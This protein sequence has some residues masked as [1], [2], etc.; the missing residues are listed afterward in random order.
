MEKATIAAAYLKSAA[1]V[2]YVFGYEESGTVYA[3]TLQGLT[4]ETLTAL[5]DGSTNSSTAADALKYKATKAR[6]ALLGSIGTVRSVC[7]AE[8]FTALLDEMNAG[9]KRYNR[10]D[11]FEAALCR[12]CGGV[13]YGKQN[14]AYTEHGD[15]I[16]DG[17]DCQAKY[18]GA[19]FSVKGAK[20]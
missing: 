15:L 20:G 18:H 3:V 4:V 9:G 19:T 10:G 11:A 1:R 12:Y 5:T 2:R 6:R 17:A 13:K 16:L 7:R 8:E 14:A